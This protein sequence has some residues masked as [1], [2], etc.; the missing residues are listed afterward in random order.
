MHGVTIWE[1]LLQPICYSIEELS[2]ST[3]AKDIFRENTSSWSPLRPTT[4]PLIHK[5]S[6]H[7][8]T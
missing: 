7:E 4:S 8:P 5:S 6:L 1:R 3:Y 2:E